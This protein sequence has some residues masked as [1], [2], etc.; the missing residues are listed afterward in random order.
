MGDSSVPKSKRASSDVSNSARID[1]FRDP[2]PR[3]GS[4]LSTESTNTTE[5]AVLPQQP[6]QALIQDTTAASYTQ[7]SPYP[8]TLPLNH[9]RPILNAQVQQQPLPVDLS[10]DD[11][12]LPVVQIGHSPTSNSCHDTQQQQCDLN[13]S[14]RRPL[15]EPLDTRPQVIKSGRRW[16]AATKWLFIFV[17]VS[18]KYGLYNPCN[19]NHTDLCYSALFIFATWWWPKYYYVFLPVITITVALNCIMVLSIIVH[20]LMHKVI[21]EKKCIPEEPE[22]MVMLLPCYNETPEECRKSLDSLVDQT[23]LN[24]HKKAIIIVVDGQA[25]GPG[26]EK[27]TGEYLTDDIL[28]GRSIREY[29]PAGY[30]AWDHTE[31]DI[32]VQR[33]I[34]GGIPYVCIVK[35]H[36]KGKRD[37]LILIRSFLYNFNIRDTR[38]AVILSPYFF[39]I[40]ASFLNLE[41]GFSKVDLLVGM[42]GDTF[43]E[44]ECISELIKESRYENTVGVCGYVAVD[45]KNSSWS[46]WALYQSSEYT[47]SQC[48]R[49]LHQ[50]IATHKVSCLP[51]CCQL[52]KV[53]ESTCGDTIL[54]D[55]FGYHPGPAD[56]ILKQIRATASEDRNHVCLMLSTFP[57]A[58]TRQA[59]RARA[60]TDVPHSWSVFL[61]QRRRWTLGATSNDLFLVSASG[62][63]LFERVLAVA[64]V[65][66][67][68]LNIFIVACIASFIKA[69]TCKSFPNTKRISCSHNI[70]NSPNMTTLSCAVRIDPSLRRRYDSACHLLCSYRHLAPP[71][72]QGTRTIS[73]W[74]PDLHFPGP[75]IK[76]FGS[77]VRSEEPRQL[78]LG[79][80]TESGGN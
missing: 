32:L 30:T 55:L 74:A 76:P 63:V 33:G 16:I 43:F 68:F 51:G 31:M 75:N 7:Q 39:G 20:T 65:M 64:N 17:L 3:E 26:M 49:R 23:G 38:P 18:V 70:R 54:L 69:C 57:K 66:T 72:H 52:L 19:T 46:L 8:S 80:N 59:L 41:A 44:P 10:G 9:Q 21:P 27:T 25:R 36:N 60:F 42:D 47:I 29:I 13:L 15:P 2:T 62:V 48:L 73:S 77:D 5:E 67:W 12:I 22:S 1:P 35:Q 37:G 40:L 61:S 50:S 24:Q 4:V 53:C 78:C 45:F 11:A 71:W 6:I 56:N 14:T 79:E 28:T 58:Q 34:Y